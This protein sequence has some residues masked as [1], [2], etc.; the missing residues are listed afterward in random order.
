MTNNMYL[1]IVIPCFNEEKNLRLGA[2]EKVA[3]FMDKRTYKW[4]VILVDDG[5]TDESKRLI[6]EFIS[7]NPF[8][9][10]IENQH[11]GKALTVI[12][13]MLKG[14]GELVLFTD[15]DQA[16]PINELEKLFPW[17][18]KGFDIVIGSRNRERKGAPLLRLAMARGF[19]ILRNS[20]LDLDIKDTQCGFKLFS[21]KSIH[22]VF[23]KMSIYKESQSVSGSTVTAG[24]DVELLYIAKKL[25]YKVKE[26]PVEWH[27][28][29]TRNVN[30]FK[31]SLEGLKD[32]LRIRLNSAKGKYG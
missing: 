12:T 13:G 17:I 30:P 18:D 8:F 1:S 9:K 6:K 5:S 27:Y 23:N 29:E 14:D 22:P 21:K 28:Q 3:H 19:M 2:L 26:V 10:L 20:I 32:L 25:K 15:L 7:D 11:R 24:F 16:T 31:D 4:E